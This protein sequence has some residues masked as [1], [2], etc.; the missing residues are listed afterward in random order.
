MGKTKLSNINRP[1]AFVSL[2]FDPVLDGLRLGVV[3]FRLLSNYLR[4]RIL[5]K[6]QRWDCI[7][8]LVPNTYAYKLTIVVIQIRIVE[9]LSD[10]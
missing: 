10:C 9:S 5:G 1:D 3:V 7:C 4:D 8:Q 2:P 6:L